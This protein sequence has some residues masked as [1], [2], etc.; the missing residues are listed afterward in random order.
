MRVLLGRKEVTP[1]KPDWH[2]QTPLMRAVRNGHKK[3]IAL[4]Q[5]HGA[6]APNTV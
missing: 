6:L 2:G 4:L 3:V 1:D 5:P